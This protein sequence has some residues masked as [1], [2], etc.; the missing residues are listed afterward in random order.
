VQG[1]GCRVQET[2]QKT[3]DKSLKIKVNALIFRE[4]VPLC[5]IRGQKPE[6]NLKL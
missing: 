2:E 6:K 4:L 5:G 3:K 1:A